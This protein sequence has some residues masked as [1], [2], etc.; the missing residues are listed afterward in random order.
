MPCRWQ[1]CVRGRAKY[2]F[3]RCQRHRHLGHQRGAPQIGRHH[4]GDASVA[5]QG[6]RGVRQL[7]PTVPRDDRECQLD[8]HI[9]LCNS[10]DP[11]CGNGANTMA[12]LTDTMNGCVG[13][14]A[15]GSHRSRTP[16]RMPLTAECVT[17]E[18]AIIRKYRFLHRYSCY[19]VRQGRQSAIVAHGTRLPRSLVAP[20]PQSRKA[21]TRGEANGKQPPAN[22]EKARRLPSFGP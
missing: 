10:D 4:P 18:T 5:H 16:P 8:E 19:S 9:E 15:R 11:V 6:R 13:K 21:Q 20:R 1:N 14:A 12:R 2:A 3:S 17:C 22:M 7:A